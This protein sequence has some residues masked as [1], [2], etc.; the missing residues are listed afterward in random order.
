[1][2]PSELRAALA[3]GENIMALLRKRYGTQVNTEEFIEISY[4]LRAGMETD[5]LKDPAH[6]QYVKESA[7]ELARLLHQYGEPTSYLEAGVGE[8]TTLSYLLQAYGKK[9]VNAHGFDL[10]WSRVYRAR[11]WL[12]QE[13]VPGVSLCTGSLTRIPFV[14]NSFDVVCTVESV[15]E[16][17][18]HE[19]QILSELYRVASRYLI[20]LEPAFELAPSEAQARMI[21]H[22]YCRDLA[23]HAKQLGMRVVEYK[24]FPLVENP[25]NPLGLIVIEKEPNRSSVTPRYRCPKYHTPLTRHDQV[26]FSEDSFIVYPIVA[27]IPCLRAENAIVAT[28]YA[29]EIALGV[30]SP[31]EI[32]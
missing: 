19:A 20:L 14:D 7:A 17:A 22:G 23:G 12:A 6:A 15:G 13:A 27:Q 30:E 2:S 9:Q 31:G 5:F 4:D 8:A 18:A 1:M 28:L 26:Y 11:Q 21:Q 24:L 25:L 10:C 3:N 29:P 16:N 32:A